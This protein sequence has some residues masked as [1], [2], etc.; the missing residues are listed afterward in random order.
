MMLLAYIPS[1]WLLFSLYTASVVTLVYLGLKHHEW[2]YIMLQ[3]AAAITLLLTFDTTTILPNT[4]ILFQ[5]ITAI[6]IG[7][8]I[9]LIVMAVFGNKAKAPLQKRDHPL[10]IRKP[11]KRG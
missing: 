4:T 6:G 9:A 2:F 8:V 11:R 7:Y 3:A 10:M 5:R 1:L